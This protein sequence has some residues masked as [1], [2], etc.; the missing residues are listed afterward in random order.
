MTLQRNRAQTDVGMPSVA[1]KPSIC[2]VSHN[3]YGAI[4]GQAGHIGGVE[5]QTTSM[6]RWLAGRGYPVSLLTWDE[7]RPP[8][9]VLHGVRVLK[10]CRKD[11]GIPGV[12]FFHPKWTG[13]NRALRTADADVCY[14]NCGECVTGQVA[15]WCQRN[16]RGFVFSAASDADCQP[17][18]PELR[19]LRERWLYRHG[20][21]R[22][23]RVV[24]QTLRQQQGLRKYFAVGSLVIPMPCSGPGHADLRAPDPSLARVLWVGRV[25][26]VKRPDRLLDLAE[27]CPDISFDLVGPLPPGGL[28]EVVG[29]RATQPPNLTVH[30]AVPRE[31]MERFY[32]GATILCCTSDYEGFPN[33]FL[34][35]WSHG[36]P[37]VSTVDPDDLI[38]KRRLGAVARDVAGMKQAIES[39]LT[40]PGRFTE[41]SGN[42]R[43]YYLENHTVE[44][45]LPRFEAVLCEVAREVRVRRADHQAR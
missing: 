37:V 40:T 6:A 28:A 12:R 9:E 1:T 32:R 42:A 11:A 13:L 3:S 22:A 18:L 41:M 23:H 39:L 34:E 31:G 35:A 4:S 16:A 43:R 2:I 15:L 44:A 45:V 8:E 14:H 17:R 29:T 20:L 10:V 7:G 36:V 33:T 25:A 38:T 24:V 19:S 5:W 27:A 30:G 21:R 26:R